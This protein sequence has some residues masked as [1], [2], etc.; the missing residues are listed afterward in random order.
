[1]T[2]EEKKALAGLRKVLLE[3]DEIKNYVMKMSLQ[4]KVDI[5]LLSEAISLYT[6]EGIIK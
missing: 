2:N 1:M 4:E 5:H 6:K 3:D